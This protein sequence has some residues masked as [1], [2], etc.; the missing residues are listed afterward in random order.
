MLQL[1]IWQIPKV[2]WR[3]GPKRWDRHLCQIPEWLQKKNQ[4]SIGSAQTLY[5][6]PVNLLATPLGDTG[7]S[8]D[9]L[10]WHHCLP[11]QLRLALPKA[12]DEE[13]LLL[14][15]SLLCSRLSTYCII[16][17]LNFS[18]TRRMSKL[19]HVRFCRFY[20]FFSLSDISAPMWTDKTVGWGRHWEGGDHIWSDHICNWVKNLVLYVSN[21]LLLSYKLVPHE[22]NLDIATW[23][24]TSRMLLF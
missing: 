16:F 22:K 11:S 4:C 10:A 19:G 6:L 13:D 3:K 7:L 8:F 5:D 23:M 14:F 12:K 2:L 15:S 20:F 17:F 1:E 21:A 24:I 18:L 9:V